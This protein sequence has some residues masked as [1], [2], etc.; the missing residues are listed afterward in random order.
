LSKLI[1]CA[2][3]CSRIQEK[4]TL[5]IPITPEKITEYGI[6]AVEER[7]SG[8]NIHVTDLETKWAPERDLYERVLWIIKKEPDHVIC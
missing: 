6:A 5:V 1:R 8:I 4:H 3:T 2:I 7:V